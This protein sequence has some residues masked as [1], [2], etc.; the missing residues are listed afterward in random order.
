MACV[1]TGGTGP[2][3]G[4]S[5]IWMY[6]SH[7]DPTQDIYDGLIGPIIIA[8]AQHANSDG[9]P[10]DVSKE[11]VTSVDMTADNAGLWMYHCHV[12]DHVKGGMTAMYKV[13]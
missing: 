13:K 9:T 1:E 6:H 8:S 7:V 4:G 5:K 12:A 11:F 2:N 3:E 10:D